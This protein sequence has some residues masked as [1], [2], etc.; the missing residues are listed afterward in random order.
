MSKKSNNFVGCGH[1]VNVFSPETKEHIKVE[2]HVGLW[3]VIEDKYYE[4]KGTLFLC[5]HETY[6]D[7]VACVIIDKDYNLILDDVWN[8]FDDY[9]EAVA[10]EDYKKEM[11]S[12]LKKKRLMGTPMLGEEIQRVTLYRVKFEKEIYEVILLDTPIIGKTDRNITFFYQNNKPTRY[13]VLEQKLK[14]YYNSN[15]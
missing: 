8:G 12:V 9:E 5:E 15:P 14:E 11:F 13:G 2:G 4:S 6:G 7:E 3:Y 10:W 1:V